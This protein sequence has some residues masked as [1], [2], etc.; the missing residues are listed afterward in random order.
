ML[1]GD[2]GHLVD[3]LFGEGIYYAIRSGKL[4]AM[5]VLNQRHDRTKSLWD[6]EL[7][8]REQLYSEFR[9]ASRLAD[10]VYTF[11]RLCY[12]LLSP[13]REVVQLYCEV[14]QGKET[15]QSFI[16]RAKGIVKSS[17]SELLLEA[18]QLR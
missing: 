13:Y 10:I 8:V 15:Y 11:P 6:Y 4:A 9:I 1:V 7:A 3:P 12:R 2:A 14:L 5:A 16:P 17:T 18:L